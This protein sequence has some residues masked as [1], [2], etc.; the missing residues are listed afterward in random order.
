MPLRL[1]PSFFI[2][3]FITFGHAQSN[4]KEVLF[5][6]DD[7]PVY[8]SE[9]IR[10]YNKNLGLVK[11]ESQKN[12]DEYLKLFVNYKLKIVEA[13][14]L[15]LHKK[16]QYIRE[17]EGYKKQLAKKYLTDHEV[18]DALVKEAYERI[19]Y[20]IQAKHILLRL[21]ASQE[22]TLATYNRILKLRERLM[23]EDFEI[24]QKEVHNGNTILVEDLG[25]FS[26][27]K[28][29][30]TFETVAFNT[31]IGEV[32]MP[33]RTQFGYHVVKIFDK[34]QS[35]GDVTVG[36]ILIANN[37]KDATIKPAL[38]IQ[39][40]N[41][42]IKQGE[43][44]ESLAK[45][46]SDDKSSAVKGGKL[47]TFNSG[48]LSSSVFEDMAFSLTKN[49]EISKPFKTDHGWHIVKLYSRN[50]I[51]A[52][53]N[54]KYELE[55]KVRR[56]SRSKRIN[57]SL[58]KRLKSQYNIA[59]VNEAQD[60]FVSILSADY[61]SRKW[62]IPSSFSKEKNLLVIGDKTLT[63]QDFALFL[64]GKQ[65]GVS[66]NVSFNT[67]VSENY[68]R[69]VNENVL[70][71]YEE[72][73]ENDNEEFAQVVA[74]YREGLLLFD[75]MET[76]LWAP[77]KNDTLGIQNYYNSNKAN[78][79]WDERIDAIVATSTNENDI[80]TVKQMLSQNDDYKSIDEKLNSN[81]KQ[82]VIFTKGM[83]NAQ[84]QALPENFN[85]K[86]GVSKLYFYNDAYHVIKV[87]KIVPEANKTF[88]ES[89]GFVISDYQ[90]LVEKN[91]LNDL[92]NKYKVLVNNSVLEKLK[93]QINN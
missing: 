37:Q 33:F 31:Q 27:F 26:G 69:F 15:N 79:L 8:A 84:H 39:E 28:M 25:Y 43:N 36:H 61:Y 10:I 55:N 81:G 66:H 6:I 60:Y 92:K 56:D 68:N 75:L 72:N 80:K 40:I 22:D 53:A 70:S 89:K 44:F 16:P 34:R 54:L 91:W 35:R 59:D 42:L 57:T 11:D 5:T 4:E 76:K 2:L 65:K 20:D 83:M 47:P 50:P 58:L 52:F 41:S 7:A 14:T 85:F 46:F 12:I 86:L 23:N 29:V 1:I 77:V 48:Q 78:Y 38:R 32:S 82:K 30:Y 71:Y 17:L 51:E 74:E 87:N 45:Q 21:D 3:F 24:V 93:S 18:T 49:N 63:Y 90:N 73:L 64:L 67:I 19:S 13:R 9:F 62:R 88:E